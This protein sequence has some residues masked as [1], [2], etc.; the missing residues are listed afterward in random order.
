M[1]KIFVSM[2]LLLAALCSSQI[3]CRW[4]E[5]HTPFLVKV[6]MK[7]RHSGNETFDLA[8][9]ERHRLQFGR[10]AGG[11]VQEMDEGYA[12]VQTRYIIP[13]SIRPLLGPNFK[14]K[15]GAD[16]VVEMYAQTWKAGSAGNSNP[17]TTWIIGGPRCTGNRCATDPNVDSLF[18]Y[19]RFKKDYDA[20]LAAPNQPIKRG[21]N[22]SQADLAKVSAPLIQED[23]Y[24]RLADAEQAAKNGGEVLIRNT[25]PQLNVY[26]PYAAGQK[27]RHDSVPFNSKIKTTTTFAIK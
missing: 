23:K 11:A 3:Y 10:L 13:D 19:P 24:W 15:E 21:P 9:G 17:N 22:T 7:H 27:T 6:T 5:N 1:K 26:Y 20:I 2:A 16:D 25:N 14:I 18:D 8:P 4:V 12:I